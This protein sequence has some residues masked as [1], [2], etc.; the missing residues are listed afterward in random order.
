MGD[1][2]A[3][4][5]ETIAAPQ[6]GMIYWLE[7][8][9]RGVTLRSAP[10]DVGELLRQT[11]FATCD[12]VIM[13]SATLQVGGSFDY[14]LER[15]GL[16]RDTSCLA[17]ASPFDFRRQALLCVAGDLPPPFAPAY[18]DALHAALQDI[19]RSSGGQTLILF[20]SHAA[21][22]GAYMALR[23][24]LRDLTILAQGIDGPRA[25]L[26]ERFRTTPGTVLLGT[27]SFWEGVDLLGEALTCLVIVKLPFTV[28]TDPIFA[29]PLRGAIRRPG[30]LW[31][32][33][34]RRRCCGSSKGLGG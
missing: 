21:L 27:S 30:P 12:C 16:E 26:L 13:T 31:A 22:R 32:M 11:L 28:P 33:P 29:A 14:V 23:S 20:T 4:L 19:C 17:V 6:E 34:C 7:A 15:L 10:L 25:Q 1:T 2:R 18:A 9:W 3:N 5:E 24:T 8:D